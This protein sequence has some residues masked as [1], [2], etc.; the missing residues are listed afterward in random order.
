VQLQRQQQQAVQ[1]ALSNR[2]LQQQL[3][4]YS[5]ALQHKGSS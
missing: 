4:R 2:L 1:P 3:Q 5:N